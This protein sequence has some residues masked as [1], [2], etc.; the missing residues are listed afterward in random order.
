LRP[1][2]HHGQD[3]QEA[4]CGRLQGK[5][6]LEAARPLRTLAELSRAFQVHPVQISQRKKPLLDGVESLF[7]DGRRREHDEGL[8]FQAELYEQI[9][10]LNMEVEWLKKPTARQAARN[11]QIFTV[12][13]CPG[14]SVRD[15]PTE[16]RST[17]L[18]RPEPPLTPLRKEG[19]RNCR[20]RPRS[21]TKPGLDRGSWHPDQAQLFITPG[22]AWG[23]EN[24]ALTDPQGPTGVSW[25]CCAP[26]RLPPH[27]A[28]GRPL[29]K[30]ARC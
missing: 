29:P 24:S 5:V 1:E 27:P 13:S 4:R 23:D 18:C 7:G 25:F 16:A 19:K 12:T 2:V 10:R 20:P 8:A 30:G 6:A 22:R 11:C 9:G 14:S 15:R 21:A 17:G 3:T 28:V 26:K